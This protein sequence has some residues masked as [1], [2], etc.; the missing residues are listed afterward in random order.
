MIHP[1]QS[2][3]VPA[4]ARLHIEGI[5]TGFISSLGVG[6]VSSLYEAI[7]QDRNSFGFVAV[8]DGIVIGFAAFS[9]SLSGLYK[10][11]VLRKGLTFAFV[12]AGKMFSLRAIRKIFENLFY[13]SK[14]KKRDLPDAELLSIVVAPEGRS[15]GLA[16]RLIEAGLEECRK[17]GIDK[18]KVLVADFNTP[19]NTLYQKTG[20]ERVCQIDSHGTLSNVY[21]AVLDAP[22]NK[23]M[24][25]DVNA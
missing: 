3:Y 4:V 10:Q 9:T 16:R 22:P 5:S 18:V 23:S 25:S 21:V 2:L 1:L 8:D 15:K 17:R 6:F 24:R 19:A 20:F 11:V 7:A 12:I 13:H 14:M